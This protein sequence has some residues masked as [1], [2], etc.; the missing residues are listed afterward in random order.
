MAYGDIL[1]GWELKPGS[2]LNQSFAA[3]SPLE[4]RC[5][6]RIAILT[7]NSMNSQSEATKIICQPRSTFALHLE[8]GFYHIILSSY[9]PQQTQ[10]VKVDTAL[11]IIMTSSEDFVY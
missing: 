10:L 9:Q 11:S 6:I 7:A 2:R 4:D 1:K 5:A 3:F 8:R